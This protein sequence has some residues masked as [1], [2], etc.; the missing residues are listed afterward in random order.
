MH[1]EEVDSE[2]GDDCDEH[3]GHLAPSLKLVV[4][5]PVGATASGRG[6]GGPASS[7]AA[8]PSCA[9]ARRPAARVHGGA[10]VSAVLLLM[11]VASDLGGEAVE[12]QPDSVGPSG[13]AQV[14]AGATTAGARG[15]RQAHGGRSG[16][17]Y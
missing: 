3:L 11:V 10:P 2:H 9:I 6:R 12:P 13:R 4:Q 14:A 17:G 8:A 15:A 7:A 5:R 16:E 1:G